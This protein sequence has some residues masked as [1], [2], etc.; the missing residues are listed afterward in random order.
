MSGYDSTQSS[1]P[2]GAGQFKD[3]ETDSSTDEDEYLPP[4]AP[5]PR[6][7]EIR[8]D[9]NDVKET[10]EEPSSHTS[11]IVSSHTFQTKL[12]SNILDPSVRAFTPSTNTE[13]PLAADVPKP[14]IV[15]A[16]RRV[17]HLTHGARMEYDISRG[18]LECMICC[19]NVRRQSRIWDCGRCFAVFHLSCI[20]KWCKQSEKREGAGSWRCPGCQNVMSATPRKYMCWCGATE[21]PEVNKYLPPH[22]CGQPCGKQRGCTH[23]CVEMCHAG[24]CSPC[25]SMAPAQSCLCGKQSRQT[26]CKDPESKS[27]WS[28]EEVCG[29][30]MACGVHTCQRT[31]HAGLCGVCTSLETSRCYC[32]QEQ[33]SIECWDKSFTTKSQI[34]D[35]QGNIDDWDGSFSCL[36]ICGRS[37]QCGKHT[38]SRTCHSQSLDSKKC[39]Y[40]PEVVKTCPC[41]KVSLDDLGC[42]RSSCEDEIKACENICGRSRPCG[43]ICRRRC[44]NKDCGICTEEVETECRCG[45]T[46]FAVRCQY[47]MKQPH[48]TKVCRSTLSCGRHKCHTICCPAERAG[49]KRLQAHKKKRFTVPI[50]EFESE[51]IC[52]ETCGRKLKCSKHLCAN[53]CHA[54]PCPPCLE[55][56]YED[57]S[58]HCR[59]TKI[60]APVACSTPPPACNYPCTRPKIC[61]HPQLEHNCH[62]DAEDC[63]RCPYLVERKCL[64]GKEM[65]AKGMMRAQPCWRQDVTCGRICGKMLE[66]AAHTCQKTCHAPGECSSPCTQPCGKPRKACGHA[67]VK[68][69][70]APF[71][72]PQTAPCQVIYKVTCECGNLQQSAICNST[73]STPTGGKQTLKCNVTCATFQRNNKLAQALDIDADHVQEFPQL[74]SPATMAFY[75]QNKK[76][77]VPIESTFR[78][79]AASPSTMRRYAFP[80]MKRPQRAFLHGLAEAY[81]V[82]SEAQDPEPHRKYVHFSFSN[83]S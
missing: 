41:G 43:H 37:F 47:K 52:I 13:G 34:Q 14:N 40:R 12:K 23:P 35:A 46:T 3:R 45:R 44:H 1:E 62:T 59:K 18:A 56:T 76:W 68:P 28:C 42:L 80:S 27:T 58:C 33:K 32:G 38:C 83:M 9:I 29:E 69:C 36:N 10:K 60:Y 11:K 21:N 70:H 7:D 79:F 49:Q 77:S 4:V 16:R 5:A 61:G 50:E 39:P 22:S 48:C 19:E 72:C 51:H 67:C 8:S 71:E 20:R 75:N 66:C 57:L 15:K 73:S 6:G 64:C 74:Y 54:G 78:N 53:V 63:P 55:A 26:R 17:S 2:G 65:F 82:D 81:G 24:P 30:I 31:C 25:A